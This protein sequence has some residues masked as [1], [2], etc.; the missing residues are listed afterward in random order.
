[1]DSVLTVATGKEHGHVATLKKLSEE[2]S[3]NSGELFDLCAG[4]AM[5][6]FGNSVVC[7]DKSG[8]KT[9]RALEFHQSQFNSSLLFSR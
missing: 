6:G 9:I 3:L 5:D 7:V 8:T 2:K 4:V 1:M